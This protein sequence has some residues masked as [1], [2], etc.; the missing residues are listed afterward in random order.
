MEPSSRTETHASVAAGMGITS[1]VLE[2]LVPLTCKTEE[3]GRNYA[4]LRELLSAADKLGVH[5][6]S[7]DRTNVKDIDKK[8]RQGAIGRHP[9]KGARDIADG[10]RSL[11]PR[12]PH[13][14]H[15]FLLL[16]RPNQRPVDSSC[17]FPFPRWNGL[18]FPGVFQREGPAPHLREKREPCDDFH[19]TDL[20]KRPATALG[21]KRLRVYCH[22]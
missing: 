18:L 5:F 10:F 13:A 4:T 3:E 9:D 6:W 21:L 8:F 20:R 16:S 19:G 17:T 22:Q 11:L 7:L 12:V 15:T 1:H 2:T 14:W